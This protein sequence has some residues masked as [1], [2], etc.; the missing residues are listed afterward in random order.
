MIAAEALS[1][2]RIRTL[3]GLG[4][5]S[6][7]ASI[8]EVC[9]V[10]AATLAHDRADVAFALLYLADAG[11]RARLVAHAGADGAGAAESTWPFAEARREGGALVADEPGPAWVVPLAHHGFLVVGLGAHGLDDELRQFLDLAADRIAG[12]VAVA[13]AGEEL[14]RAKAAFFANISHE[15]RTPLTLVLGPAE[16]AL[17]GTGALDGAALRTVHRNSL[18]LLKMVDSLLELARIE[19]GRAEA[20]FQATDLAALTRELASV[21]RATIER[22]GVTYEVDCPPLP[23]VYVDRDMWEHIVLN[24]VS[25]AF[26]YTFAGR[27]RISLREL[28]GRAVLEVVDS[29]SGIPSDELPR[30]FERFHRVASVRSRTDEGSGVGLALVQ[31]LV[32]IHGG[33]IEVSSELGAGSTFRVSLPLGRGHLPPERIGTLRGRRPTALGAAPYLEEAKRW[34]GDEPG[35]STPPIG[36]VVHGPRARVLVADENADMR[37]YLRRLL[38]AQYTVELARDGAAAVAG[39][40]ERRPDL[41][42]C[43]VMMRA[44]GDRPFVTALRQDPATRTVPILMLSARAAEEERVEG[45]EAG[46]DD[47]LGKPFSARELL[48]RVGTHL[49]LARLRTVAE[50]ERTRLLTLFVHA[51]VPLCIAAGAPPTIILANSSLL[52]LAGMEQL[53]GRRLA[54]V[55]GA[56]AFFAALDEALRHQSGHTLDALPASRLWPGA[57]DDRFY[58]LV[59]EPLRAASGDV[60]GVMGM[61]L[62]VTDMVRARAEAEQASR[63]KDEFLAM[64][65]HELRNPLAPILT[66]LQL[67]EL[68]GDDGSHRERAVI[69]RQVRHVVHLVDDLL[70][71]SRI[72]RGKIELRREHVELASVVAKGIEMASPLIEQRSHHLAVGVAPS[73]LLVEGD[74]V[75]LAQIVSNLLSNAAKYTEPGGRIFV[76]ARRDGATIALMVRDTGAGI[77]PELLPRVFELFAQGKRTLDR[78]QGGLGIGLTIVRSLVELHGGTVHAESDGPGRGSTFHVRLPSAGLTAPRAPLSTQRNLPALPTTGTRVLVVDDNADAV[79]LLAESLT[80]LG[81]TVRTACDAAA[82]LETVREFVPDVALLD[83]G[84]PVIDGYELGRRLRS[85]PALRNVRLVAVTGYG[86]ES[87][88]RRSQDAGFDRHLVKPIDLEQVVKVL[89]A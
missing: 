8:D 40:R 75:R 84:L 49:E 81:Y 77:P 44:P 34:L 85:V 73:G 78:A 7:G 42:L 89:K 65:G 69:T 29:G 13:R 15:L 28:S 24:L 11:G 50:N 88:R 63:A 46:A 58:N 3:H 43:D 33:A 56:G 76:T 53:E 59:V 37:E 6:P 26:K 22:G 9:A 10:A 74:P 27:I 82:A 83:I 79:E 36:P 17:R 45:L 80:A 4:T 57:A 1:S 2:L 64:L 5:R 23:E 48:A 72:T 14:E 16:D 66:A 25:N 86:Q 35:G 12:S 31:Q 38:G 21:F 71:V 30:L 62:E 20:A 60:D 61:A 55:M 47:Y 18:R 41:I 39:A 51:P 52:E 54:D 19:A 87:D 68:R 67:M 70:D 32:R